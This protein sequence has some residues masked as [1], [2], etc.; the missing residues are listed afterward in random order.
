VNPAPPTPGALD[1]VDYM[2]KTLGLVPRQATDATAAAQDLA[3]A[4]GPTTVSARPQGPGAW[5]DA[6][7]GAGWRFLTKPQYGNVSPL[8][9]AAAGLPALPEG[10]VAERSLA[11]IGQAYRESAGLTH[12]VL[13]AVTRV[14]PEAGRHMASIYE[15]LTSDPHDPEVQAHYRQFV[16]E[17]HAQAEHL[18]NNGYSWTFTDEDPYRDA[19]GAPSSSAMLKDLLENKHINVYRTQGPQGHPLLTNDE[20]NEFRAVHEILGHGTTGA[21]FSTKGEEQAFR[22]HAALF[23][24]EAQR[25]L[26]TETRGQNSWF[27]FGPHADVL[28]PQRLFAEQKAALWPKDALGDYPDVL[29]SD[30]SPVAGPALRIGGKIFK[31]GPTDMHA[32]VLGQVEAHY[33]AQGA[34]QG[35][36]KRKAFDAYYAALEKAKPED[37]GFHLRSGRYVDRNEGFRIAEQNNQMAHAGRFEQNRLTPDELH[38]G[39]LSMNVPQPPKRKG[40]ALVGPVHPQLPAVNEPLMRAEPYLPEHFVLTRRGGAPDAR[41]PLRTFGP[42]DIHLPPGAPEYLGGGGAAGVAATTRAKK[43]SGLLDR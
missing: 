29:K 7:A 32:Q 36:S 16:S 17:V 3:G 35:L 25:V 15:G 14:D 6:A 30:K 43:R 42:E 18:H 26:A 10:E 24:P 11:D 2:H 37:E 38:A 27:N 28:S 19:N 1:Y 41:P 4:P 33:L 22:N 31:G 39:D 8:G 13:P 5:L 21:S 34:S 23:S 12:E 40:V 20:N 9:L